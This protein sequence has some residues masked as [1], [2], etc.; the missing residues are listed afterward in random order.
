[1]C[2][3]Y[4]VTLRGEAHDARPRANPLGDAERRRAR[5]VALTG[6]VRRARP[7]PVVQG[8]HA[9][10]PRQRRHADAQGGVPL[11]PLQAAPAAALR[12]RVRPDRQDRAPR[13]EAAG[14]RERAHAAR[15]VAK[16][17]AGAHPGAR[18][19][20]VRAADVARLVPL[21]AGSVRRRARRSSS[22]PTPSTTTSTRKSASPRSR[23]SRRRATTST[24]LARTSAAGVRSTTTGCST[25]RGA[26]SSVCSARCATRSARARRS[27]ASSR[28]ASRC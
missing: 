28:A 19:P 21:A 8:L 12:V 10:L 2:P 20:E 26:T 25:S 27:S 1:M 17:L 14:A 22:G 16:L 24:F 6:G 11:A 7:L 13:V 15:R 23:R 3:S 18:V 5:P 4:Q 9:R